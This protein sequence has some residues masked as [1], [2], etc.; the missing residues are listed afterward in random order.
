MRPDGYHELD[1]LVAKVTLYDELSVSSR[2]DGQIGLE[3]TGADCGPVDKNLAMR[4]ALALRNL[5]GAGQAGPGAQ[6]Q[7]RKRIPPGAGLGGGSSDA[8]TTLLALRELWGCTIGEEEL[9][10]LAVSLGSDVPLFLAGPAS[11]MRGRGEVLR[12]VSVRPFHA[13]LYLS[14]LHCPT[15]EVYQAFDALSPVPSEVNAGST[16][17]FS[18]LPPG[19]AWDDLC[20]NDLQPAAMRVCPALAEVSE[21]LARATGRRVH[22][23]GSG[24]GLFMLA[25][26]QEEAEVIVQRLPGEMR[27]NCRIVQANGF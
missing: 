20:F 5:A 12:P 3:C 2:P 19:P 16:E 11:R 14:G 26:S 24:S 9:A 4:A 6:M 7:L 15:K 8:A 25:A 27:M 21:R 17:G 10:G 13:V 23:T 18:N 22:M 1:S